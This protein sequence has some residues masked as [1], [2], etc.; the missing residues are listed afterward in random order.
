M[1]PYE[2]QASAY[3]KEIGRLMTIAVE[4]VEDLPPI[5]QLQYESVLSSR[6]PTMETLNEIIALGESLQI[7]TEEAK[8][9]FNS[10]S[11][12]VNYNGDSLPLNTRLQIRFLER[13]LKLNIGESVKTEVFEI[14]LYDTDVNDP[15]GSLKQLVFR[16]NTKL[17]ERFGIKESFKYSSTKITRKK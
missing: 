11:I 6:A 7:N 5:L 4:I 8:L 1:L 3:R 2:F 14:D 12:E 10:K 17:E 13:M 16:I 15:K 9:E